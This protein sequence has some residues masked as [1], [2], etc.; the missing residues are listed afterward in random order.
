MS[1][2]GGEGGIQRDVGEG[3]RSGN[4]VG[5]RRNDRV[6]CWFIANRNKAALGAYTHDRRLVLDHKD[7]GTGTQEDQNVDKEQDDGPLL[8]KDPNEV[9]DREDCRQN[10]T[11]LV[12]IRARVIAWKTNDVHVG[13]FMHQMD[14]WW[15]G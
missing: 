11:G 9:E 14:W 6:Y 4:K 15:R 2:K 10:L 12:G 3:G 7:S 5:E 1:G 8:D 13:K